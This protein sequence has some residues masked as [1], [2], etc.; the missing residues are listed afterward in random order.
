[1]AFTQFT[2]TKVLPHDV[3]ELENK[4]REVAML[5]DASVRPYAQAKIVLKTMPYEE[6]RPAQRYVL[7]D[8]LAKVQHL[9]WELSAH[10]YD[11]LNLSGYLTV[12]TDKSDEPIDLLP[13]IIEGQLEANGLFVNVINDG[14]HRLYVGRQEWKLPKVVHIVDV[15]RQYPYY[16]YPIPGAAPWDEVTILPGDVIPAGLI[17]KFHRISDNKRLYRDFNSAFLNVGGPR[18]QQKQSA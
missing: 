18:G 12:Y 9:N 5:K 1:M 11:L 6:F 16:A 3:F 8:N 14:M 10:G 15:P 13:P 4:L 17:K 7:S 2:I